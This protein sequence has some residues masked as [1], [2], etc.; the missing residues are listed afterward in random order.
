MEEA[1]TDSCAQWICIHH[2]VRL[3]AGDMWSEG[4]E[5]CF[6]LEVLYIMHAIHNT[7]LCTLMGPFQAIIIYIYIYIYIYRHTDIIII[8]NIQH[9]SRCMYYTDTI[10]Y[11]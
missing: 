1:L 2:G 6:C 9:C 4:A 7:C 3:E 8:G 11:S 10:V 5:K